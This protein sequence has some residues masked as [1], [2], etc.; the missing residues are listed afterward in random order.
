MNMNKT[1]TFFK[2]H[3]LAIIVIICGILG[4]WTAFTLL[5]NR[6]EFYKDPNFV[7]TCSVNVWLDCGPVMKSK[8]ADL[9]GFP[10]TII[11][12]MAYPL[13]VLTGLMMILNPK[14]NRGLMLFCNALA[15]IGFITNLVLLYISA[16]LISALCPWC[17]LAGVA[18]SNIFFSL[19][20]YN[21]LEDN[22]KFKPDTQ[23]FLKSRIRGLF[24][25]IPVTAFYITVFFLVWLSFYLRTTLEIDTTNFFDPIF[26]LWGV[27]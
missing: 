22:I 18:T 2:N 11:G 13:A 25:I 21:V 26:W 5:N 14:N 9:F 20:A 1:W 6:I 23:A 4:T 16:Y 12:L 8:W 3:Y 19:L 17:L 7:P 27:K 24:T 15:G 10:N